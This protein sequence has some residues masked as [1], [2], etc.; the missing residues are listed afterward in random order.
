MKYDQQCDG[1]N[2]SY[3]E[4]SEVFTFVRVLPGRLASPA[5]LVVEPHEQVPDGLGT[6]DDVERRRQR[7]ALVKVTH[8]QLGA[9]E[10][11]LDVGVVLQDR[12]KTAC[13]MLQSVLYNLSFHLM[14]FFVIIVQCRVM[15]RLNADRKMSFEVIKP[16]PKYICQHQVG[17]CTFHVV[18]YSDELVGVVHHRDEHVEQNHQRDDIV[19]AEHGRP[20]ELCELVPGLDVGDVQVQQ[21]EYGPEQRLKSLK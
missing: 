21:P 6:R 18:T 8:P 3:R 10:L 20:D 2:P 4:L 13:W 11:P 1:V 14:P 12:K 7:A 17:T 9:G 16:L 5:Q 15:F 19:R